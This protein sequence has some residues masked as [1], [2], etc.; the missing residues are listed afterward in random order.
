MRYLKLIVRFE[1]G[2]T[3]G[4]QL[5]AEAYK[6]IGRE[7]TRHI[8]LDVPLDEEGKET[9]TVRLEGNIDRLDKAL[10]ADGRWHY[11]IVD[12]KTG[13]KMEEV[14]GME[15]LFNP[16]GNHP[17]YAFQ[18]FLYALMLTD[19]A[20]YKGL[21]IAPSLIY[22]NRC[23]NKDYTPYIKYDADKEP[24]LDFGTIANEFKDRFIRLLQEMLNPA[25][26]FRC[27]DDN[28]PCRTCAFTHICGRG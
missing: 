17:H 6:V 27:A 28:G 24:M 19:D 10:L 22:V 3:K 2:A 12:Y 9:F 18:T 5:P 15:A 1:S 23:M 13:G 26:P 21:P 25:Q 20:Q 16:G 8:D 7:M 14:K 4:Q 11:R